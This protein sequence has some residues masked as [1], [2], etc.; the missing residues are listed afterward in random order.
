MAAAVVRAPNTAVTW[1]AVVRRMAVSAAAARV[2][3]LHS[4]T[5][6][7]FGLRAA[8]LSRYR[9]TSHPSFGVGVH[10]P[11]VDGTPTLPPNRLAARKL[12]IRLGRIAPAISTAM[13]G[14]MCRRPVVAR[15]RYRNGGIHGG[16]VLFLAN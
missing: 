13:A 14:G 5:V 6:P 12:R 10:L 2:L 1:P 16:T 15:R 7:A 9:F 3:F 11:L 8:A 4:R